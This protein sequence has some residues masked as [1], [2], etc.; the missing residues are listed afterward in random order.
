M[1]TPLLLASTSLLAACTTM[2]DKLQGSL[3][4]P[5]GEGY[6]IFSLVGKSSEPDRSSASLSW[7]ALDSPLQ[8]RVYANMGTN[9]IFGDK[10]HMA[11]GKLELLT[12]PPGRYQLT[13]AYG[14]WPSSLGRFGD[15]GIQIRSFALKL[16]FSIEAG[17]AVY[18]GEVRVEMDFLPTVEIGDAHQRDFAYMKNVWKV[19]TLNTVVLAPF[20]PETIKPE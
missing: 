12:L 3:T 17:K 19:N 7:Q 15:G 13:T 5:A 2:A 11:E 8:G 6:A 1:R 4:P 14:Y 9:T 10:G 20:K 16:P 18:L